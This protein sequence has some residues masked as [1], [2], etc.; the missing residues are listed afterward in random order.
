M[1]LLRLISWPYFRKHALRTILTTAGIILGLAV[2]I[3]MHTANQ[4]VL[5]AFRHTIDSIAGKAELQITAGE[6]GFGEEVLE[7]VQDAETV[8]VAVPLVEAVVDSNIPGQG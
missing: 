2:F 6:A 4:S 3:G 8:A 7:R 1:I 5:Y